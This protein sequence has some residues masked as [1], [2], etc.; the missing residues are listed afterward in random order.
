[1]DK[2]RL[3]SLKE[4]KIR[5]C[6]WNCEIKKQTNN[7]NKNH[8]SFLNSFLEETTDIHNNQNKT[9]DNADIITESPTPAYTHV[10]NDNYEGNVQSES[11]SNSSTENKPLSKQVLGE[12]VKN[13][14]AKVRENN[15]PWR[16]Q[17][18]TPF[19]FAEDF[20]MVVVFVH[21]R[22]LARSHHVCTHG[23][24][25]PELGSATGR[26]PAAFWKNVEI[27]KHINLHKFVFNEVVRLKHML[28]QNI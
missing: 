23:G 1:M 25:V 11:D 24:L 17:Q 9:A 13:R 15:R 26:L 18:P 3:G 12:I 16:D 8:L 6:W 21:M 20:M 5:L 27:N 2:W 22:G 7:W 10:D 14:G 4:K 28:I 19:F